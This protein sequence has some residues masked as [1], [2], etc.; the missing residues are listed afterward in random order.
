[1]QDHIPVQ[2]VPVLVLGGGIVGLSASLFLLHQ[3]VRPL[4]VERHAG[5]SIHPRSRGVNARTMELYREIGVDDAV[6]K[7]GEALAPAI[8]IY[9]G[10]TLAEVLAT[11]EPRPAPLDVAPGA[12][13]VKDAS[14]ALPARCTQDLLEPILVAAARERGADVFFSTEV[15]ALEQDDTGV[16]VTMTDRATGAARA[17]RADYVI[18]A[19]GAGGKTRG[20]LGIGATGSGVHG[21]LLNILF[22]ADLAA[23]VKNRELSLCRIDRPEVTGLFVSID[24]A[25]RW[26]F[27]AAYHPERGE[28]PSDYPPERCV[29]LIRIA[30]GMPDVAIEILGILPWQSAVRVAERFA[31]GRVFLAGDA[32]HQMP[33]WGG[34]GANTGIADVHNLAWKLA[35]VLAGRADPALLAT[36]DVERRPVGLRAAEESAEAGDATGLIA[37][38]GD[39][40]RMMAA[41]MERMPRLLGYGYEYAS[42]AVSPERDGAA[43]R[44]DAPFGLDG[45]PGTRAPHAWVTR[46]GERLSTLALFGLRFVLLAGASGRVWL[47][48]ARSA[49][50]R[51]HVEL[52]AYRVGTEG[53]LGDPEKA[54]Q[55]AAGVADDGALLVRPD[56]FVAWRARAGAVGDAEREVD[57]ALE[58]ALGRA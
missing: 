14:P 1:M 41:M 53:E 7:A 11:I 2:R 22:R 48:A 36:Y 24:N 54:W 19:D 57:E 29:E 40:G 50:A 38:G 37:L 17:V 20:R 44:A 49:A 12:M 5:T 25:E 39:K 43:P 47:E 15:G 30:L 4:V 3:G 13:F 42:A 52:D 35:A 26:A 21:H 33:P 31:D 51:L 23:R 16:T 10:S 8:G 27:H 46:A 6:R 18:A 32:A 34:Q 28:S 58:R 9:Q 45:R 55:A 56:G